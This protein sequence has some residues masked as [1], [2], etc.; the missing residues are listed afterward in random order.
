[1]RSEDFAPGAEEP[2]L[3]PGGPVLW[4][5]REAGASG[6]GLEGSDLRIPETWPDAKVGG[7]C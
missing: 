1:M 5:G 3:G 4:A 6:F 7:E 2:G